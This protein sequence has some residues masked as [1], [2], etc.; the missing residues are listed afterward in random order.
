M[1]DR[2]RELVPNS[3]SLVREGALTTELCSKRWY[4][5]HS[6]VCRYV[7]VQDTTMVNQMEIE[8]TLALRILFLLLL[9][10]VCHLF[11]SFLICIHNW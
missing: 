1:T 3:W 7:C 10:S 4:S 9:L 2:S 5:E 6:G 8:H 11:L